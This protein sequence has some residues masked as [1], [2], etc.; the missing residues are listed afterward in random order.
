[1]TQDG[2]T[3]EGGTF[4]GEIDQ[5]RGSQGWSTACSS[6]HERD[7]K[8]HK[9]RIAQSKRARAGSLAIVD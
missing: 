5:C 2:G 7:G 8:D 1:M 9:E 3:R 6:L 4:G